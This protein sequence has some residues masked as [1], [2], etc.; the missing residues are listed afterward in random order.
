MRRSQERPVPIGRRELFAWVERHV[1]GV[2]LRDMKDLVDGRVICLLLGLV[3]P[4]CTARPASPQTNSPSQCATHNW[5]A[6]HR[7]FN[8]LQIPQRLAQR[9]RVEAADEVHGFCVLVLFYFLHSVSREA[10]FTAEFAT[11]LS[12]ELQAFLESFDSIRCLVLGGA[13]K[14]SSLPPHLRAELDRSVQEST[15][16]PS[17]LNSSLASNTP[18]HSSPNSSLEETAKKTDPV[19]KSGLAHH[20]GRSPSVGEGSAPQLEVQRALERA[21][22]Q[23]DALRDHYE[24][25]AKKSADEIATLKEQGVSMLESVSS[26]RKQLND[27][28]SQLAA[29][30]EEVASYRAQVERLQAEAARASSAGRGGRSPQRSSSGDTGTAW[31]LEEL[32][33]ERMRTQFL[34]TLST[35]R[36][37]S[38]ELVSPSRAP[39]RV[40]DV[41]SPVARPSAGGPMVQRSGTVDD[42]LPTSTIYMRTK[43]A[44]DTSEFNVEDAIHGIVKLLHQL[45]GL[46]LQ[47]QPSTRRLFADESSQEGA[48]LVDRI[49]GRLWLLVSTHG[50]LVSRL[51]GSRVVVQQ[52]LKDRTD[53]LEL[54]KQQQAE[55]D[56][57]ERESLKQAAKL[58]ASLGDAARLRGL[59]ASLEQQLAA[60]RAA[61]NT[62][63]P[64]EERR[65]HTVEMLRVLR[66]CEAYEDTLGRLQ[67][68]EGHWKALCGLLRKLA[69]LANNRADAIA[70]GGD[71]QELEDMTE[72]LEDEAAGI[73]DRLQQAGEEAGRGS[74]LTEA[75]QGLLHETEELNRTVEQL[76]D[77]LGTTKVRLATTESSLEHEKGLCTNGEK[78]LAALE[79]D[80]ARA[81]A[82]LRDKVQALLDDN[83][84]LEMQLRNTRQSLSEA[85][86][87]VAASR[88]P[89]S[90]DHS[91]FA[92][93]HPPS[94]A[95]RTAS[96]QVAA[97]TSQA[98]DAP[99]PYHQAPARGLEKGRVSVP[100]FTLASPSPETNRSRIDQREGSSG[101]GGSVGYPSS[102]SWRPPLDTTQSTAERPIYPPPSPNGTPPKHA[103]SFLMKG[104]GSPSP[105]ARQP[106]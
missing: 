87:S 40:D 102:H 38:M 20:R 106:L 78:L 100:P 50:T 77:E 24:R 69:R 101:G 27:A 25:E 81:C 83:C 5:G 16:A 85:R 92:T 70:D 56:V 49:K 26:L 9:Q 90:T 60:S 84:R 21:N 82:A 8:A 37:P 67:E 54:V 3:F 76:T 62:G 13:I 86:S 46:Q 80:H 22:A 43:G 64:A 39:V 18:T 95:H 74:A 73:V 97:S 23:V 6:V 35:S 75:Y 71:V 105:Q 11:D 72:Q 51:D 68:R 29:R 58:A 91:K 7:A 17:T 1:P 57:S 98:A 47:P 66:G 93:V 33:T 65:R 2:R 89:P 45:R 32:A 59:T 94:S 34:R 88:S 12:A 15:R 52:L 44:G 99:R 10:N 55:L 41:L 96:N 36:D 28:N 104:F 14:G 53:L 63:S 42:L 31:L 48:E 79:G 103:R 4:S 61:S 19:P 30:G